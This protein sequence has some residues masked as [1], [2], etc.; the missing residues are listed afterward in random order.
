M[1][2]TYDTRPDN[3]AGAH[4]IIGLAYKSLENA[5]QMPA[6]TWQNQ[7]GAGQ[8]Y[9]GTKADVPTLFDQLADANLC[10]NKFAFRVSR[11]VKCAAQADPA[12]DPLNS[13]IFVVGGG[14]EC[15]DLYTGP[16]KPVA[17]VHEKYYNTNLISIQVGSQPAIA[18]APPAADSQAVSNSIVDSGAYLLVL[19]QPVYEQVLASFAA[20]DPGLAGH[21]KNFAQYGIN[22]GDQ[23]VIDLAAWPTIT[24]TLQGSGGA[25]VPLTVEPRDYW[26][27]DANS[28]GVAVVAICGDGYMFGGQSLLGLPLFC[29]KYVVFDRASGVIE[30]AEGR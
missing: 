13:G 15:T 16:F 2:V 29:G 30:F 25:D 19:D 28:K 18:V 6:D 26:Q 14:A 8:T 22:G 11:S 9:L 1:A 5:F 24:L 7:Y 23:A 21:L 17:I 20:I 12:A 4:G 27:L 3:F 10:S